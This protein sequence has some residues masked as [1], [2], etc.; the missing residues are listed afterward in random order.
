MSTYDGTCIDY[1][2]DVCGNPVDYGEPPCMYC[3]ENLRRKFSTYV[4]FLYEHGYRLDDVRKE[5]ER[6]AAR[7]VIRKDS[8]TT[9]LKRRELRLAKISKT[10]E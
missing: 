6:L 1:Y 10:L 5:F 7:G 3:V 8:R 4:A 9:A 2:C